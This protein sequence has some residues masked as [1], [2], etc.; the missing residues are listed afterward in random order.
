[1]HTR[2]GTRSVLIVDDDELGLAFTRD[3]LVQRELRLGTP[4]DGPRAIKFYEGK[5]SGAISF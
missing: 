3:S 2:E 4:A 1:V 5:N